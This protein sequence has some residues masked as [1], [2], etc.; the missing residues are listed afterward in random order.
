[1]RESSI[2]PVSL[3]KTIK[4]RPILMVSEATMA[5]LLIYRTSFVSFNGTVLENRRSMT[6]VVVCMTK[7]D[8]D[9]YFNVDLDI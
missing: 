1:M 2:E 8:N 7:M 4:H 3:N 9:T 6:N 5:V